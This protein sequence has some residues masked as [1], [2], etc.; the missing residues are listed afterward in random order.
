MPMEKPTEMPAR[1][2][3]PRRSLNLEEWMEAILQEGSYVDGVAILALGRI[4][5]FPVRVVCAVCGGGLENH[6]ERT[7]PVE[8]MDFCLQA[9]NRPADDPSDDDTYVDAVISFVRRIPHRT[10]TGKKAGEVAPAFDGA[11]PPASASS[12]SS[13]DD[14]TESSP[15]STD[16]PGGE[17]GGGPDEDTPEGPDAMDVSEAPVDAVAAGRPDAPVIAEAAIEADAPEGA[18][19][20]NAPGAPVAVGTTRA[21]VGVKG[22]P[23]GGGG[24]GGSPMEVSDDGSGDFGGGDSSDGDIDD[25]YGSAASTSSS[26]SPA[27]S[28][29]SPVDAATSSIYSRDEDGEPAVAPAFDGD[30]PTISV[31]S[32]SSSVDSR[33]GGEG[34]CKGKGK[35]KDKG[36]GKGRGRGKGKQAQ[37][38]RERAQGHRRL[39]V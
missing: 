30:V 29:S 26:T 4:F 5:D 1:T 12:V 24:G 10:G 22:K 31:S 11:I 13:S 17:N 15:S 16:S 14:S 18:G 38:E 6:F 32:A 39:V 21:P 3:S 27:A 33:E 2:F 28:D 35:G 8:A 19:A 34:G 23:D 36:K 20:P 7:E 9:L 25:G 37:E